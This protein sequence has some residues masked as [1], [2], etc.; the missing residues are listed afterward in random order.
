MNDES[1]RVKICVDLHHVNARL[2]REVLQRV[3]AWSER[4]TMCNIRFPI[5]GLM[6]A[7]LVVALGL[8]ALR[9]ASDI[10]AGET[11]LLTC[12]VL[13]LAVVGVA[14]GGDS[15]RA[16]W[17]GF[18]LFGWGYLLLALWSSLDLP[19]TQLT[20]WFQTRLNAKPP[21]GGGLQSVELAG[22]FGGSV[23]T[24]P[25][26]PFQQIGHCLWALLAA[27]IGGTVSSLLFGGRRDRT[28]NRDAP[29]QSSS[30][31]AQRRRLWPI[32]LGL[33]GC[34]LVVAVSSFVSRLA[35]GFWPGAMFLSTCALLG[36]LVP[37]AA[38]SQGTRR[39][40]CLGAALFGIGYMVLAFGRPEG[41]E[42]WPGLPSDHLLYALRPW[43]PPTVSGFPTSSP[44]IAA[45][46]ARIREALEQ[47][48]PM[49]FRDE[50]PLEDVLKHITIET[51]G[52]G[53]S[54]IPIY[55]DPIGLQE[56]DKTMTST[57]RG[58]D[59]E[60]VPLK[61]SLHL[62]L[63]QL[64]LSYSIRDGLLMITSEASKI[65]PIDL[66][67]FLIVGHC[68]LALLAAIVGGVVA[69]LLPAGNRNRASR[70]SYGPAA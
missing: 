44:G 67:P 64:D 50:T 26:A 54:G 60:G 38:G 12:A 42:S 36:I 2:P 58:L 35:S 16:W 1:S 41:S 43:F 66:D 28:E 3:P 52:S 69:L 46:N 6:L 20:N 45:A 33:S 68:L 21:G 27:L 8:A 5:A 23:S 63:K 34:V 7:V 62:M 19:T 9:N 48:V 14:C 70:E 49:R 25:V 51:R 59:F 39:Q 40:I 11:F 4:F 32:V 10:W 57:V 30:Q 15:H 31:T 55:V 47:P 56:A 61:R 17:L 22:G 29:T 65:T 37:G 13:T 53:G 24:P 18:A